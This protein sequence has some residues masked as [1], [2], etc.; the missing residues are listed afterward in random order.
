MLHLTVRPGH[1]GPART[2][3]PDNTEER[4]RIETTPTISEPADAPAADGQAPTEAAHGPE[5]SARPEEH[6]DGREMDTDALRAELKAVRAEA[7]RY[8]TKARETAEALK[9]ARPTEEFQA[10]ADR[11]TAPLG[12]VGDAH[13]PRIPLT[14]P[15]RA[16]GSVTISG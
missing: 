1:L 7:A 12:R 13:G 3:H 15:P 14:S 4:F 6:G 5:E 11:A 2:P 9:A 16:S 10:V 8:R